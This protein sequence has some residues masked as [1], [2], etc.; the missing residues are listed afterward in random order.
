MQE[1]QGN[2]PLLL[3][4]REGRSGGEFRAL[5]PSFLFARLAVPLQSD[6]SIS[7][8]DGNRVSL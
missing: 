4:T 6:I 3:G 1:A 8:T 5:E 2:W 7:G